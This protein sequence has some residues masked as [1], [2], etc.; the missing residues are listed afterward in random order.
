M[1]HCSSL[2][3]EEAI[4]LYEADEPNRGTRGHAAE[5]K[6]SKE[7]IAGFS[8][9]AI[10]GCE[11]IKHDVDRFSKITARLKKMLSGLALTRV[12]CR[13]EAASVEEDTSSIDEISNRLMT[14]QDELSEKLD[15]MAA[16]CS[17]MAAKVPTRSSPQPA[18]KSSE[19]LESAGLDC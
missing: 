15:R 19:K 14:F 4:A 10:E 12:I 13:I 8:R 6:I 17:T 11:Q 9:T 18:R 2:L 1:G 16:I 5:L 7:A 3:Y